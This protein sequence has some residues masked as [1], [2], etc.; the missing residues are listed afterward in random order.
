MCVCLFVTS[1]KENIITSFRHEK[2]DISKESFI[3]SVR[4]ELQIP[5]RAAVC[6]ISVVSSLSSS[7]V[8]VTANVNRI[9]VS[10]CVTSSVCVNQPILCY[11][12]DKMHRIYLFYLKQ[13]LSIPCA[14]KIRLKCVIKNCRSVFDSLRKFS[15]MLNSIVPRVCWGVFLVQKHWWEADWVR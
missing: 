5:Q 4:F 1:S 8:F 2:D 7:D 6:W 10:S 11:K 14:Y 15:P 13:M 3:F 9:H 12:H